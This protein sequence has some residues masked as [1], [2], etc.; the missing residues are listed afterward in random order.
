MVERRGEWASVARLN[1]Q[2]TAGAAKLA[3]NQSGTRIGRPR[4]LGNPRRPHKTSEP[5]CQRCYQTGRLALPKCVGW[6]PPTAK[7]FASQFGGPCPPDAIGTYPAGKNRASVPP[8]PISSRTFLAH[9][10]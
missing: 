7:T 4:I 9:F 8:G 6:A 10:G 2:P 5:H 1:S 3:T